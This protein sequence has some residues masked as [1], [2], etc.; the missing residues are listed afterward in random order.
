M[1]VGATA[2]QRPPSSGT[3]GSRG[4]SR[5]RPRPPAALQPS[6]QHGAQAGLS[7]AQKRVLD[8]EK[9]LQFLQQQH[10]DTLVRL[11][12]EIEYLKRENKDLHYK[13]I[14]NQ[15]PKKVTALAAA[16]S[17]GKARPQL[18]SSK[19]RDSKTNV[20]QKMD[21]EEESPAAALL[22][23]GKLDKGPGMQGPAKDEEVETFSTV[24]T[25]AAG[26][27]HKGK[28]PPTMGLPPYLRKPTT[29]QQCEV[30]IRQLWNANLLQAQELQHLKTL[31]EGKQRPKAAP[32][33]AGPSSP[34]DQEAPH[35]G[36]MQLPKVP[37]KGVPMKCLILSPMPVAERSV[38]PTLKQNLKSS[39]AERQKR[40]QVVR[41][42]RLHRSVL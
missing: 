10:S 5:P 9:S 33:E 23:N 15:K 17:Q 27:Q 2:G 14:M 21:L 29:L 37:T 42:R 6:G 19:K 7:E 18:A 4:A 20:P 38:L 13:L 34:K 36:A 25:S 41:S 39:F 8:L 3:S 30:V 22:H 28:Q 35:L 16:N 32:E 31:L 12:E 26:G 11:H 24:A 1:S 40:L